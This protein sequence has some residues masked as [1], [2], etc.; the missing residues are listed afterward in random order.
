MGK[1]IQRCGWF[2]AGLVIN[3]FGIALITKAALGTSPIS[4]VPYVLSFRFP[5]TLGQFSFALNMVFI[6]LQAVLLGKGFR[7][8]QYLQIVVNLIFSGAIDL[9]MSLLSWL[10]PGRLVSQLFF[11]FLGCAVLAFGISVEVAPNLLTVPGEGVVKAIAQV[12]RRR[13]GSVKVVFDVTLISIAALLSFGFFGRLQ[14][15]GLG[16]VVSALAVGRFVNFFHRHLGLLDRIAVQG[17]PFGGVTF[18]PAL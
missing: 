5:F 11:L 9:S 3:S 4:S 13:F 1:E 18:S 6:L 14:G 16:T 17:L 2:L 12:A 8:V 7:P 10:A 15:L